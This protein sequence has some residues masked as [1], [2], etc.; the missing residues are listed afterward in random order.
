MYS[1]QY[2]QNSRTLNVS[3]KFLF[4]RGCS[5]LA[6]ELLLQ[7]TKQVIMA[8]YGQ[9]KTINIFLASFVWYIGKQNVASD[10]GLH[11]CI[12]NVLFNF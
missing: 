11:C 9:L 1:Y 2:S 5:I 3:G 10:Q 7:C 4:T 12:Q 8:M 6:D